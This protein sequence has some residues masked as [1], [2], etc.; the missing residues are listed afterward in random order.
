MGVVEVS[1]VAVISEVEAAPSATSVTGSD[2]SPGNVAR[3]RIAA[4][5]AMELVTSR[6]TVARMRTPATT[7]T[8]W[9]TL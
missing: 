4:T 1:G 8:R 9:D 5:S 2:I 3:K 7:V 6:G